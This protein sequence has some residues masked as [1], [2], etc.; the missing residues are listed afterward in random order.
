MS[1]PKFKTG[2]RVRRGRGTVDYCVAEVVPP[3]GPH[4]HARYWIERWDGEPLY[5]RAR[6]DESELRVAPEPDVSGAAES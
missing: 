1:A 4:G 6:F 5:G 3:R 2:E